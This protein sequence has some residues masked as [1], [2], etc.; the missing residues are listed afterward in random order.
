MCLRYLRLIWR[1]GL[2]ERGAMGSNQGEV[3]VEATPWS[4]HESFDAGPR[5]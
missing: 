4:A 3:A 2:R 5:N 1:P